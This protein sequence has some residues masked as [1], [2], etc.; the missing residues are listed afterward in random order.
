[1]RIGIVTPA[2]NVAPYIG[3]AIKSV[4]MQTHHDWTMVVVD[5]GST[6]GTSGV[7]RSFSDSRLGLIGQPNAGVSAARN[8]GIGALACDATLFLD[9]DDCLAPFA[10]EALARA[11]VEAP[12]AIA[13]V[14][15]Y[16]RGGRVFNPASGDLLKPLLVRNLFVN[17]GHVL[18]R[19][20]AVV[21]FRCDLRYGE[22]WEYW[23]RLALRRQEPRCDNGALPPRPPPAGEGGEFRVVTG[24]LFTATAET[25]PILFVRERPGGAYLSMATQVSSFTACLEAIHGNPALATRFQPDARAALRQQAKAEVHWVIGRELIRHGRYPEGLRSLR[26]SVAFRATFRRVG[27]LAIAAGLAMVPPTWRGPLRPYQGDMDR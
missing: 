14:G 17:G 21:P 11:L 25:R 22:D 15:A 20:Q 5:D 8:R 16:Q 7:V 18:I 27:L 10:L 6:D 26:R 4:L 2:F 23:V 9:G 24:G 12:A 19:R 1:M 3:E 13:S